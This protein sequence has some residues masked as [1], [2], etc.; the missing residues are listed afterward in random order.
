M[1]VPASDVGRKETSDKQIETNMEE[2][3]RLL[4]LK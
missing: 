4:G 1:Q 2:S 3:W